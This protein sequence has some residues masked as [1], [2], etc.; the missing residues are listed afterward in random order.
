MDDDQR[1][2]IEKGQEV[3]RYFGFMLG[4]TPKI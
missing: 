4:S 2:D 3:S 1:Y